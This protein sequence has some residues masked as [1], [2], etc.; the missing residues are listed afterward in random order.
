MKSSY[1]ET[2]DWHSVE[3]NNGAVHRFRIASRDRNVWEYQFLS[4]IFDWINEEFFD[5]KLH[6]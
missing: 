1:Y 4:P 2:E 6:V 3:M 5:H